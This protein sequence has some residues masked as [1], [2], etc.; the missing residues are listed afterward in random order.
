VQAVALGAG[1][2]FLVRTAARSWGTVALADLRPA[3]SPVLLGS[4][5]TGA[6]YVYIVF[7][8]AASLRW[9]SQHPPFLRA[10]RIWFVSNLAR[11]IP[12][13]VWQLAGLATLARA[14]DISAAAATGGSL[15]QQ[16]VLL[17]TGLIVT[18]AWTPALLVPW[19]SPWLL[20]GIALTGA[21]AL[22]AVLP[23]A[24]P[25]GGRLLGR[26]LRRTINWPAPSRASIAVYVAS[27]CVPWVVYGVSFWLFGLGLLGAGAPG[28]TLAV[29]G[30]VASYVAGIIVVFAPSGLVV[31]EAALVAA[32]G[33]A[34]GAGPALVLALASRLWLLVVELVTALGVVAVYQLVYGRASRV[35]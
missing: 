32:L 19:A 3:W 9:W 5:L 16:V 31:R 4:V 22:V 11:F 33:P 13:M 30:F 35:R 29:G 23:A 7:V 6:T 26:L 8:W 12:G 15:L 24:L 2:W 14:S 27:L 10:A 34:I 1:V 21:L 18:A 20:A 25:W 28:F 17:L